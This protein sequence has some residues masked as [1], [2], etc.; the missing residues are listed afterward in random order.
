[1]K[2]TDNAASE[3]FFLL[4]MLHA[5]PDAGSIEKIYR[6]LLAFTISGRTIGF[7]RAMLLLLDPE[8]DLIK[9]HV[10]I[11][12]PPGGRQAM[13]HASYDA[14]AKE[15]FSCY[16]RVDASDL[17]VRLKTY[18]VPLNWHRS[19][20]VKA[21]RSA[22]PVLAEGK[23]SE[24]AT[25]TFFDYFGT[26]NYLAV[27]IQ[28][29]GQVRAVLAADNALTQTPIDVDDVSLLY[30]LAQQTGHAIDTL[31]TTTEN[32]RKSRILL[33]LEQ[34][35]QTVESREKIDDALKLSL[36]MIGKAVAASGTFIKDALRGRTIHVK[37]VTSF[38]L[39]A[40]PDDIAVSECFEK[41][42][43]RAAGSLEP[44]GGDSG[45][46]LVDSAI[47]GCIS[48]FY[49]CPLTGTGEV[50]GALGVY[51]E[52]KDGQ[53]D[54]KAFSS[55]N[56][57]FMELCAGIIT[58]KLES[59]KKQE[60]LQQQEHLVEEMR[61]NLA[62]E[63]ERSRIGEKG[64]EFHR[65]IEVDIRRI[66]K[67]FHSQVTAPNRLSRADEIL[68]EM[69]QNTMRYKAEF[70]QPDSSF[71]MINIFGV[72]QRIVDR[73]KQS[74]EANN[75]KVTVRIPANGPHLLMDEDKI[76]L[77]VGNILK[78]MASVL[79]AEDKVLIECTTTK[80]RVRIVFADTGLGL[81]GNLLS[82][83]F[84]PFTEMGSG[85]ERKN[86]LSLA[87]EILHTHAGE[88]KVKTSLNWKTM[89]ELSF[90]RMGNLD[91]RKSSP[92]RRH[93]SSDRRL[94]VKRG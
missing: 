69:E 70:T 45:H 13:K 5:L 87:G 59:L 64:I 52:S 94:P 57:R 43:D 21:A 77:A 75:I 61:T 23:L 41:I 34:A 65:G 54:R 72:V 20:L 63:R 6:M 74:V 88:I 7:E 79:R 86:A 55:D 50:A 37:S 26:K 38:S 76:S 85:D 22:F 81:P 3:L 19:A 71:K 36:A 90:V 18:S 46:A 14:M 92:D 68:T 48:H 12:R 67:T 27:P 32:E 47:S 16:E 83:L 9:G 58:L 56:R 11:Q 66:R 33:K 73:W 42:L 78:S 15:A 62:R 91:R 40:E 8:Q 80:D 30:S 17:T 25:D 84:M 28:V 82:R 29:K 39:E 60:R 24:F 4:R 93:K 89:L 10:G 2:K 1:M 31:I 51:A 44:I 49:V 53:P 35:L